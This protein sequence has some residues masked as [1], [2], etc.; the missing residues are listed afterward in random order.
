MPDFSALAARMDA[1]IIVHL[2]DPAILDGAPVRGMFA[3]PWIQPAMGS[4]RTDV[5]EPT[6]TVRDAT[7]AE[8]VEGSIVLAPEGSAIAP[9][10]ATFAVVSVEPDGTGFT[11]LVLREA[12]P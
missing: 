8:A 11:A 10:G 1:A 9:S 3:A 6:F 4:M 5:V 7:A 2:S 12:Q